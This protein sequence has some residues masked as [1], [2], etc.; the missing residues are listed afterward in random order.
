MAEA[1][2][3]V[4]TKIKVNN[5]INPPLLYSIIY[6]N[7]EKTPSNFVAE[8]LIQIF[9]YTIDDAVELTEKIDLTGS[10]VAASGLTKELATHLSSLVLIEAQCNGYPL[11]VEVK[12]S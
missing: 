10:G 3:D 5:S 6:L 11:K 8:T 12:E 1:I 9:N 4:E 7:D 2:A